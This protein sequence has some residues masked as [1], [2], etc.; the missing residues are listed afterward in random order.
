[1]NDK[2][3]ENK[4]IFE[5]ITEH[6]TDKDIIEAWANF[7]NLEMPLTPLE[8]FN[9]GLDDVVEKFGALNKVASEF[10]NARFESSKQEL[11]TFRTKRDEELESLARTAGVESTSYK[12]RKK[13]LEEEEKAKVKAAQ[14]R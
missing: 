11:E 10:G 7:L 2:A 4:R 14:K 3:E 5:S 12:N 1:M 8:K 9:E 6:M 13:D